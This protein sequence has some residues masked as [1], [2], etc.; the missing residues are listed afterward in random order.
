M[1]DY[2][3]SFN[4]P[5][6]WAALSVLSGYESG[7]EL[8][9]QNIGVPSDLI[10]IAFGLT[11]PSEDERGF[12]LDQIRQYYQIP[13]GLPECWIRF[14][15]LDGTEKTNGRTGRVSVSEYLNVSPFSS[16]L[17]FGAITKTGSGY[18]IATTA[19]NSS[20]I[21]SQ[22]EV[23]F[24]CGFDVSLDGNESAA[25]NLVFDD[26]TIIKRVTALGSSSVIISTYDEKA[27]GTPAGISVPVNTSIGSLAT[28]ANTASIVTS[29]T[30]NGNRLEQGRDSLD[31]VVYAPSNTAASI[32]LARID[33]GA[34]SEFSI[35][36]L[37]TA[38]PQKPAAPEILTYN[39]VQLT[40]NGEDLFYG[41]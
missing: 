8:I 28:T 19:T 41:A 18:A 31:S 39:G 27:T 32:G 16:S 22:N 40:Y 29:P 17:P 34:S 24:S 11:P 10:D 25:V 37:F 36:I 33:G 20:A 30:F 5:K 35:N 23:L 9:I 6:T 2:I 3:P 4:V 38:I 13:S 15:R 26:S 14:R 21:D 1:A 12:C 7:T